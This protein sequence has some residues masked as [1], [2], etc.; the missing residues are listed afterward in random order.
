MVGTV[1]AC[2]SNKTSDSGSTIFSRRGRGGFGTGGRNPVGFEACGIFLGGYVLPSLIIHA[3]GNGSLYGVGYLV[4]S[5]FLF[6]LFVFSW[7]HG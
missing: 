5:L 7:S 1:S 6:L 2:L 4:R 3:L